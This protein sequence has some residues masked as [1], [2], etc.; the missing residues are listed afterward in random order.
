MN[1]VRLDKTG[2]IYLP[3]NIRTKMEGDYIPI[4]LPDN[5]IILHKIKKSK[6][7]LK[8]FQKLPKVDEDIKTAKKKILK[9]AL[10]DGK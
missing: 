8:I 3:K 9:Q 6:N 1:Y 4:V 10:E 5:D 7:P 2:K